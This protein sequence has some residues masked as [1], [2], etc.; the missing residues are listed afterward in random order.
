MRLHFEGREYELANGES[1]LECLERHQASVPSY[2]RNGVCQTCLMR[3][4]EGTVPAVAQQ[5]LKDTWKA[6]GWFLSC[7]C[8][9]AGDMRVAR[10]DGA[11]QHA[12][13]VLEVQPLSSRV[14]RVRL[15]R[16]PGFDYAAGQ[17]IQLVRPA[18][19]LMRPYSLASTPDEPFLEL[20]VAQ[21][22]QGRLSGWLAQAAGEQ[23]TLRG[24]YGECFYVKETVP[25]PLL[26]VGTGTGLAPLYGVLRTAIAAGHDAA[27]RLLHGAA[28]AQ[29]LY[30]WSALRALAA[31]HRQLECTGS[32]Q[33]GVAAPGICVE[34]LQ[35]LV[36]QCGLSLAEARV[37]VCGNP[38]FVR[39]LRKQLYLAGAPLARIHADPF[40]PP[41][42]APHS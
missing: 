27:I 26:L 4:E 36:Q 18:D 32:V 1:V 13:Q 11:G 8:R 34:P 41:A 21:L 39:G 6:Q 35:T 9:P 19:S 42:D 29:E 31:A 40:L 3:A 38:D 28:D 22:P 24:P 7:M 14:L 20:H 5:G 23:V 15:T 17:F 16:P 30:L 33:A 25:R 37:Y 2:C 10:C 12:A